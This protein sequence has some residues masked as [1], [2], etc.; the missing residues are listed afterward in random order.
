M[1]FIC[2][3]NIFLHLC[4]I[5]IGIVSEVENRQSTGSVEETGEAK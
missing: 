4:Q 3:G 5:K 2:S 1:I